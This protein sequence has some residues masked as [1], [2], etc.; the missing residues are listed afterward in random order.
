MRRRRS[1]LPRRIALAALSVLGASRGA[2][3]QSGIANEGALDFILPTGA[4]V[5]GMGQAAAASASGSEALWWNPAGIAR[6][7]REVSLGFV[8]NVLLP[9]SDLS[10]AFV[11][12]IPGVMSVAL[13]LR[14]LNTGE[15]EATVD[16]NGQVGTFVNRDNVVTATFAAPFGDRLAVGINLKVLTV[17]FDCTGQCST[18]PGKPLTGALDVGGRYVVTKDSSLSLGLSV[19]NVGLPLQIN[20]SPQADPLPGRADVGI[21]FAPR[22]PQY[23]DVRL[24]VAADVVTRLSGEGAPGYR[25]GGELSWLGQYHGR[26][27]YVVDGPTGSGPSFG[28]GVSR[29]RWRA[30]FAQ[31]V[32]D[33]S[34]ESG[35]KPTYFTLRYVF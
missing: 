18:A 1:R 6:T 16:P 32:S 29:G 19:R 21:E 31:F 30:D 14:Y 22:L 5:L 3:A 12:P 13:S 8:S 26:V 4:R 33:V 27:G 20:D 15:Q 34:A 23:P 11:Y 35:Q 7:P 9:K 2:R 24:R 10:L 25:I 17:S 28:A